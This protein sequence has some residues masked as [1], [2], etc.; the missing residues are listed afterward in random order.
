MGQPEYII[1]INSKTPAIMFQEKMKLLVPGS[2]TVLLALSAAT[3]VSGWR[4]SCHSVTGC[5][6][7]PVNSVEC[8][9]A[10]AANPLALSEGKPHCKGRNF[11][12]GQECCEPDDVVKCTE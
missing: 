10:A 9:K 6:C 8:A 3:P 11:A 4:L 5:V 7:T 1:T 2:L 12:G